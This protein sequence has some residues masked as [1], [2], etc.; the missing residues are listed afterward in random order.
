MSASPDDLDVTSLRHRRASHRWDRVSVGDFFE[1]LTWSFPDRE[2]IVARPGAFAHPVH[3]RVTYRRADERANQVANALAARGLQ[4]GDRVVMVCDNS[5]EAYLCKIGIAKAGMTCVPINPMLAPDVIAHLLGLTEPGFA[6]VDAELWPRMEAAFGR[7]GVAPGVTITIG[8]GPVGDSTD[9]LGFVEGMPVTEPDVE[10]HGDDVWEII[11]TTGTTAMPKGVMITHTYSYFTAYSF[12]LTQTRG[13]PLESDMR[14]CAFLPLIFHIADQSFTFPVWVSGGTLVMGRRFDAAAVAAAIDEERITTL[15]GGS[16]AMLA[17]I[18]D[19]LE[20][21]PTP[22]SERRLR[23]AIYAWSAAPPALIDRLKAL[24]G[25]EFLGVGIL[26]QTEAMSSHRFPTDQFE[27][28]FR[29][30]APVQNY[31]GAPNP[32]LAADVVDDEGRSLAGSP[33]VPGEVVYRGP[34]ITAGYYRDEAATREAFRGGWF[35]SGDTC[36]YDEHGLRIMLDRSKDIIKSGGENV[37]SLRVEA[38]LN[39][40]PAVS[41]AAVVGLPHDHWGEAVT[42]FVILRPDGRASADELMA[43]A[44]ERLAGFESPKGVVFVDELPLAVGGKILKY[45]LRAEHAAH[46]G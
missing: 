46:Y 38:V 35:H 36:A 22:P 10:I 15:Y 5:V 28:I 12:A 24:V 9:F 42:A 1:R 33:G 32:M 29:A 34:V 4:P 14:L 30:T 8:G 39:E 2:A 41:R 26:G 13:V 44:R 11:F 43:W 40:H 21:R 6:I 3:E 18:A 7:A 16:P 27:E 25:G 19:A 31:V 17:D 23:N 37:S 45:K 20:A